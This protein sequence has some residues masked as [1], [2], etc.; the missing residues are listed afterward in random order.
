MV[1]A[2]VE[3]LDDPEKLGRVRVKLPHLD[4]KLSNWARVVSAGAGKCRGAFFRPERGDEVVVGFE[5]DDPR[6][7]YVLGGVW[8][9]PDPPPPDQNATDN[10]LRQIV[11]R[12]G[13]VLRFD[14]TDRAERI[15]LI[16]AGGKQQVVLDPAN[17]RIE[18]TATDGDVIVDAAGDVTVKSGGDLRVTATGDIRI[19]ASGRLTL[20]GSSVDIN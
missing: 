1:V 10:N 12:S 15:E 9:V 2:V 4:D 5:K 8:S 6:R 19:E 17:G 11:T 14:D 13:H 7:P 16:A 20:R 18:V 3:D